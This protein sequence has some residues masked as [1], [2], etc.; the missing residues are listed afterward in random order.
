MRRERE[1]GQGFLY[2]MMNYIYWLML[3]NV[4]FWFTNIICLLAILTLKPIV[5]NLV[6][7]FFW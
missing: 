2:T 3:T 5:S 7:Y 1:F 6:L 4:Y